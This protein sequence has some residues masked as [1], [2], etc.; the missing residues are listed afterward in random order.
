MAKPHH[1][2]RRQFLQTAAAVAGG[3][4]AAALASRVLGAAAPPARPT[5]TIGAPDSP[6]TIIYENPGPT[7]LPLFQWAA[8]HLQ[9]ALTSRG[10]P[11]SE[12]PQASDL[13]I[14]LVIA[15]PANAAPESFSISPTTSTLFG[16]K[17]LSL[18]A[19]DPRGLA[20]AATELADCILNAPTKEAARAA[21]NLPAPIAESPANRIR[22]IFRM[23]VSEVEDKRWFYDRAGWQKYFDMLVTNR[24]NRFNLSFGLSYDFSRGLTDVYTFFMYPFFVNVPGYN[25][26]AIAKGGAPLPAEEM[27]KNLDTLKFI[28]DQ[29]AL[30]GLQFNLGIWTHNY[31][32]TAS[33]NASHT[34]EGLNAQTQAPYS[35]DAMK[36]ILEACPGITGITL[37]THGESG[38]PEGSYDLWK[39][40]MSGITGHKNADGSARIIELDMHAK[41]MT[42][43]MI[44]TALTTGMPVTISCKFWAE[45]MGLPY[46]QASIRESEMPK[47]RDGTGLMAL[48]SGTRSFLRYGIGD[49][50]TKDRKYKVI[51]RVW[52]GTQRLLLWGDPVYAAEYGRAGHFAGMD[53]IEY[54]EPL[55]FKGRAGSS[56]NIP[57][58]PDRSG[59][60]DA[61]LRA[62]RDWEKYLYTF[63]LWGR[64]SYNPE[65]KAET[66][67]RYLVKEHEAD[68]KNMEMAMACAS[69]ILP[70]ITTAHLPAAA[71]AQYWPEIYPNQ[72]IHTNDNTYSEAPN[73]KVFGNVSSLD[74]QLFATINEYVASLLNAKPLGK[75]SP[76]EVARQLEDWSTAT[77]KALLDLGADRP[78][79]NVGAFRRMYNDALILAGIGQF[80][81][82]K[83]RAAMMWQIYCL[84]GH[85]PARTAALEAYKKARTAWAALAGT[86]KIYLGDL[87]FGSS[88]LLRGH[89]A[90]RLAAIDKDIAGMETAAGPRFAQAPYSA[91]QIKV[92]VDAMEKPPAPIVRN[93]S[94]TAPATFKAGVPLNITM[95]AQ[96]TGVRMF[97][98][99]LH[100][101][102][103]WRDMYMQSQVEPN[104]EIFNATIPADYTD[105]PFPLQYYFEIRQGFRLALCP[106]FKEN[107][108]GTPFTGTP[109]FVVQPA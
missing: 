100:Q 93:F 46:V 106:C 94:H 27:Q 20:Y 9:A 39:I 41:T 34:I 51:H 52:P 24:F 12:R 105:S 38:V 31:V 50:L 55:S 19:A 7:L 97:Y 64:L 81:A 23:F 36:M 77:N 109:Y 8:S 82:H 11:S 37:R 15:R 99:Q 59:Y 17:G 90:D 71:N 73:P 87:T 98:R 65:A 4:G 3:T 25:V 53:G 92:A 88:A 95:Q 49:L 79:S 44:D 69:R 13:H 104:P 89:W 35:R 80:F 32:W 72:S 33:P 61:S 91:E 84:S 62:E 56:M 43:E 66:W 21:L 86:A 6:V 47:G 22:G 28:S 2:S 48:S 18:S 78:R 1:V 83:Y 58:V 76:L 54:F 74:P 14:S 30:R 68:A 16:T 101:G 107:F 70:L 57:A 40:I 29:A 45:H 103:T 67:Q 10:I 85:E 60:A 96:A 75:T 26:R 42:Q 108:T 5:P 63:R 102:Q